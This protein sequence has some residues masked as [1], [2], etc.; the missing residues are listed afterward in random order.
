MGH[1]PAWAVGAL[2]V[3]VL[4]DLPALWVLMAVIGAGVLSA[5]MGV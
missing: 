4:F 2:V 5:G 3:S 1:M